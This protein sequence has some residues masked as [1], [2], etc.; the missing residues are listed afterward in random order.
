[1]NLRK[2]YKNSLCPVCGKDLIYSNDYSKVNCLDINCKFN[3][4]VIKELET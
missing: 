1:M 2:L 3:K 4:E